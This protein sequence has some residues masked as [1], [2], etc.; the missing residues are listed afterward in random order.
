MVGL[1]RWFDLVILKVSSKLEDSV[2]RECGQ[3]SSPGGQ[4]RALWVGLPVLGMGTVAN[5]PEISGI[6]MREGAGRSLALPRPPGTVPSAGRTAAPAE[7]PQWG[8][9]S[10]PRAHHGVSAKLGSLEL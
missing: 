7:G 5:S 6:G 9:M 2:R 10:S 4:G 1:G 8:G 3:A